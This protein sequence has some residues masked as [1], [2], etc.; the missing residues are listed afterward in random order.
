MKASDAYSGSYMSV[1]RWP[2][3]PTEMTVTG[4]GIEDDTFKDNGNARV[5]FLQFNK[6]EPKYR[7]NKT[8][9]EALVKEFGDE[10][11]NWRGQTVEIYREQARIKGKAGWQG[12][13]IPKAAK[14]TTKKK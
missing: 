12:M 4:Y 11:S 5:I 6:E 2:I 8:N 9:A 7:V 1:E 3:E 14:P 13:I 10:M